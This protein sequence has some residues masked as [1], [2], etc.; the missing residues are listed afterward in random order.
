MVVVNFTSSDRG[1]PYG[2]YVV[3]CDE[4]LNEEFADR[5]A[6]E[7]AK[8]IEQLMAG[9]NEEWNA[10]D[11]AEILRRAGYIVHSVPTVNILAD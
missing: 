7:G 5:L 4:H 2:T 1:A 6:S 9:D 10:D 11:A 3:E 8:A